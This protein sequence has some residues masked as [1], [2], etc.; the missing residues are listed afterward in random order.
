MNLTGADG[1][2]VGATAQT[3]VTIFDNDPVPGLSI[4]NVSQNEGNSGATSFTFTVSLSAVSGQTVQVTYGTANGTA[5]AGSDYQ[6][7]SGTLTI[8][9]GATSGTITVPVYGDRAF[10]PTEPFT[11]TLSAPVNATLT[12][13]QGTG[14]ILNDDAARHTWGDLAPVPP[15]SIAHDGRADAAV[16]D[17]ATDLWRVVDSNSGALWTY[18]AWGDTTTYHDVFVPGDYDGDGLTDFAVYRP[19]PYGVWYVAFANG[20]PWN[21]WA[22]GGQPGDIAVPGDYDGDG[23]TDFAVY[24]P[25]EGYWHIRLS[26]TGTEALVE[27]GYPGD[28]TLIPAPADYDGDGKTD[29]AFYN[30]AVGYWYIV[31]STTG[32]GE[33]INLGETDGSAVPAPGDYDGDGKADPAFYRTTEHVFYVCSSRTLNDFNL[34]VGLD[35]TD[36]PV[37]A[38]YDGDGITDAAIYHPATGTFSILESTTGQIV[39][40]V[41]PAS[42]SSQIP[43]LRRP[44]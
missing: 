44:Q 21:S 1:A 14:T 42:T 5:T 35:A 40:V 6:A 8:P 15:S 24:R 26:S 37:S 20:N 19:Y 25:S 22:F 41:M 43:V 39:T 16:F 4:N 23:K 36:M 28:A 27:W 12:T 32:V 38:D 31:P 18:G 11:V 34:Y 3:V 29:V 13:A 10:E 17:P 7:T 30:P 2:T 33:A 9:A